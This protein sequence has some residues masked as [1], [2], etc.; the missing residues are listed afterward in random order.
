M[1][2]GLTTIIGILALISPTIINNGTITVEGDLLL[3]NLGIN[4]EQ[5]FAGVAE[6]TKDP[7]TNGYIVNTGEI[8]NLSQGL[9]ALVGGNG[10]V[11]GCSAVADMAGRVST[12]LA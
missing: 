6:F 12:E 9:I 5:F 11:P 1:N 7:A 3:S 8:R 10:G 4:K 2:D